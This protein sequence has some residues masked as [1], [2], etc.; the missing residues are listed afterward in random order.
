M[1]AR[2]FWQRWGNDRGPGLQV[3]GGASDRTPGEA[4]EA[5][6]R[7]AS[8]NDRPSRCQKARASVRPPCMG[9][10]TMNRR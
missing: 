9:W 1:K 10:Y 4:R 6:G 7:L 8:S 5:P 2:A 3:P